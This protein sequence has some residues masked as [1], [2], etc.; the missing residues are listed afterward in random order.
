MMRGGSILMAGGI[1][2]LTVGVAME[3]FLS[4]TKLA[5]SINAHWVASDI[6][7]IAC[8]MV[9]LVAGIGLS[10]V[11]SCRRRKLALLDFE[12]AYQNRSMAFSR[13]QSGLQEAR[14][15][16]SGDIGEAIYYFAGAIALFTMIV[17]SAAAYLGG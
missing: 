1:S 2:L 11:A 10:A 3:D 14:S 8:G 4:R 15:G 16:Q 5:E 12:A 6:L 7:M 9:L 17:L 13:R